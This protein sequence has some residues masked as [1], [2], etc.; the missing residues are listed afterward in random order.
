M[1][2]RV[3]K[4]YATEIRRIEELGF[5]KRLSA[6]YARTVY[7]A[8]LQAVDRNETWLIPAFEDFPRLKHGRHYVFAVDDDGEGNIGRMVRVV[9]G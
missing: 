5:S 6:R 4:K 1:K 8:F 2:I 3:R 7:R 9:K